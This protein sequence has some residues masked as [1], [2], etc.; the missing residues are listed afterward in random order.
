MY[1]IKNAMRSI[2]RSKGRNILIGLIVLVI[3]ISSCVALSIREA[4][5]KVREDTLSNMNVTAEIT[6]N[7][8]SISQQFRSEDKSS[9]DSNSFKNMMEQTK[10]LSLDELKK[11]AEA[12]SV[13][14]FDYTMTA[15]LSQ[16]SIKPVD[17]SSSSSSTQSNQQNRFGGGENKMETKGDFTITGYSSDSMMTDFRDGLSKITSG[18]MFSEGT[19]DKVCVIS[20]ELADYNSLSV[21]SEIILKNPN[22]ESETYTFKV[23]GI[24]HN[25]Q[26]TSSKSS[27]FM[28]GFS[29][30]LDPANNIYMSYTTL[31][32]IIKDSETNATKTTD[33]TGIETSTA[34][35]GTIAGVYSF[36]NVE[37]YETFKTQV[38][39]LGLSDNYTVVST[40]VEQFESSM[41]PL[42]NLSKFALY[43]LIVVLIIGSIILIVLNVF[44]IRERKYEIGVLTAIGMKR[45][46]VAL[47][48]LTEIFTLALAAMMIGTIVG[49]AISVPVT[50]KLLE[51]QITSSTQSSTSKENSFGRPSGGSN[52]MQGGGG[53]GGESNMFSNATSTITSVSSATNLMVV[54]QLFVIAI[55]ITLIS[56]A[57]SVSFIMR[58]EP[59]KILSNRD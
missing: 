2:T 20:D 40:D 45:K 31:S 59:L 43:F 48:F 54:L 8:S 27:G 1:I 46:K 42:D 53:P 10:D 51:S 21:G 24:Y 12:S 39:S 33:S 52:S 18:Q 17:T 55:A 49:A 56:G 14:G 11:Y 47:Q 6:V 28:R 58:Y 7:R 36:A 16:S 38:K 35:K 5:N 9:F 50:N 32:N 13:K 22:K 57:A 3:A 26:S 41:Q 4:A 19:S 23:V 44:N 25:E 34:I 30:A 15:S 37:G 29:T